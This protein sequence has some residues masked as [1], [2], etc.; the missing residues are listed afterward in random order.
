MNVIINVFFPMFSSPL[1]CI[2]FYFNTLFFS[3]VIKEIKDRSYFE[4]GDFGRV[5]ELKFFK[6]TF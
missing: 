5:C 3:H 1:K 2:F 4:Y 6:I